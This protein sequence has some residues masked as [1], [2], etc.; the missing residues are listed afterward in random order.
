MPE[1]PVSQNPFASLRNLI[2]KNGIEFDYLLAPGD[3]AHQIDPDGLKSS[4]D[5]LKL[6][7]VEGKASKLIATIGNHDVASRDAG[8]VFKE[9]RNFDHDFP[10]YTSSPDK[11][12]YKSDL[13]NKGFYSIEDPKLDI[14]FVVLNS[15]FD[16]WN[17]VEASKGK[18]QIDNLSDISE[19]IY[20]SKR[21]I[22]IALIHHHPIIHETGIHDTFDVIEGSEELM[23][24]LNDAD[25]IIHGHKHDYRFTQSKFFP[26][27]LNI[28]SAGSF[29]CFKTYLKSNSLN[30]FHEIEFHLDECEHCVNQGIIRTYAY[31]PT[32]GWA[33]YDNL[34]DG[35][36]C[37]LEPSE[38]DRYFNK[39]L[40]AV[41]E[42]YVQ[43]RELITLYPTLRYIAMKEVKATL[44]RLVKG[45]VIK[46]YNDYPNS[47]GDIILR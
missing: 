19:L 41:S 33:H 20:S 2:R 26:K 43:W 47:I 42:S 9:I 15:C 22:K 29:S 27:N 25:F 8:D 13:L 36:G 14:L 39:C 38:L 24:Y 10:V 35:F 31:D 46:R 37:T 12:E 11:N 40:A 45:S 17:K 7:K 4:W 34:T 3:F 30:Y 6:I 16:H 32:V 23:K 18:V 5:Q 1:S 21:R 44:D 28:L